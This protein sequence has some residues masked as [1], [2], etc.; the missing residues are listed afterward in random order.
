MIINHQIEL[1]YQHIRFI[2]S[3][4]QR[5]GISVPY[6]KKWILPAPNNPSNRNKNTSTSGLSNL[7]PKGMALV[8]RIQKTMDFARTK[9]PIKQQ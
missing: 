3:Q 7:N 6:T 2:K 5:N 9:Q 1:K 4:S 8:S